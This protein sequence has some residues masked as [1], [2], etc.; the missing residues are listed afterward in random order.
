M[1]A[2]NPRRLLVVEDEKHL[3]AGLKLNFTLEGFAVDVAGTA[4]EAG[5]YL[6]RPHAY[7]AIVLDI[8]LPD[9]DGFQLCAATPQ[10]LR[11]RPVCSGSLS[12]R[13]RI[14]VPFLS[15][16]LPRLRLSPCPAGLSVD[17]TIT[18]VDPSMTGPDACFPVGSCVVAVS[19]GESLPE[20]RAYSSRV[21]R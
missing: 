16:A 17:R 15:G 3:A 14:G 11:A 12:F 21:R 7:A 2:K 19:S 10:A 6:V 13:S 5:Q 4:R 20:L 9:L 8:M 18:C 1:N